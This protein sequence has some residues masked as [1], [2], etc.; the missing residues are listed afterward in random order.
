MQSPGPAPSRPRI[1]SIRPQLG[2]TL[3]PLALSVFASATALHGGRPGLGSAAYAQPQSAA[4]IDA[5][6]LARE[7]MPVGSALAAACG[8]PLPLRVDTAS[9]IKHPPGA[10][11][12]EGSSGPGPEINVERLVSLGSDFASHVQALCKKDAVLAG[13]VTSLVLRSYEEVADG[14][15]DSAPIYVDRM[16]V[17]NR[18][19]F[20]GKAALRRGY[21]VYH[22][23]AGVLAAYCDYSEGCTDTDLR[24]VPGLG[25]GSGTAINSEDGPRGGSKDGGGCVSIDGEQV[26]ASGTLG[27]SAAVESGDCS[28]ARATRIAVA[29]RQRLAAVKAFRAEGCAIAEAHAA[30]VKE[31]SGFGGHT[32]NAFFVGLLKKLQECRDA[33][34]LR[35][36]LDDRWLPDY[37]T[38]R[39]GGEGHEDE[40]ELHG[41]IRKS[42]VAACSALRPRISE[43][44]LTGLLYHCAAAAGGSL[45]SYP[46]P[47]RKA[48]QARLE[49]AQSAR[50]AAERRSDA[51]SAADAAR[52]R[53]LPMAQTYCRGSGN[54]MAHCILTCRKNYTCR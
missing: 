53:N 15:Q 35:S 39:I 51:A 19:I 27:F 29:C 11:T 30:V 41:R 45:A 36:V 38:L 26:C 6:V 24:G 44:R 34:Q 16:S 7:L 48:D 28:K 31:G 42:V 10:S 49:S 8:R 54:K 46:W 22:L 5:A 20:R 2:A 23:E 37:R 3:F 18:Y 25:V 47:T 4:S 43:P 21:T 17:G 13:K 9:F 1:G 32:P 50:A 14:K 40:T 52:R 12:P 33:E